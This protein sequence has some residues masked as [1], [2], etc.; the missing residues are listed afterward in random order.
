MGSPR[1]GRGL[2]AARKLSQAEGTACAKSAPVG[3]LLF[4]PLLV[5]DASRSAV[6]SSLLGEPPSPLLPH[7]TAELQEPAEVSLPTTAG[8]LPSQVPGIRG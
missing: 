3:P 8:Y 1:V 5:K 6:P 2:V 4:R 7:Q